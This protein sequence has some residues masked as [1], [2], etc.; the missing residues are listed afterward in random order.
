M[1]GRPVIQPVARVTGSPGGV[2]VAT[3]FDFDEQVP[4]AI[5]TP[6]AVE[7][8]GAIRSSALPEDVPAALRAE[9]MGSASSRRVDRVACSVYCNDGMIGNALIAL[10]SF[11]RVAPQMRAVM[12]TAR[13]QDYLW[14][15]GIDV[16]DADEP[17]RAA[18]IDIDAWSRQYPGIVGHYYRKVAMWLYML[19]QAAGAADWHIFIDADVLFLRG[20]ESMLR[21]ARA[22]VFAA[23]IEHWHPSIW[24]VFE[25]EGPGLQRQVELLFHGQAGPERMRR[26]TYFNSGFMLAREDEDVHAAVKDVLAASVLYPGLSRS[27]PFSEQTLF[28]I[29]TMARRVVCRDLYGMCVPSYHDESRG[30]PLPVARHYLADKPHRDPP[31]LHR[32]YPALVEA[33]LAAIGTSVDELKDRQLFGQTVAAEG[34][35]PLIEEALLAE[36]AIAE[37]ALLGRG[38]STATRAARRRRAARPDA[39]SRAT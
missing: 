1:A 6:N 10:G 9:A 27:I 17:F 16:V 3:S 34:S 24:S 2:E 30:W 19:E 4:A 29:A 31:V 28:N 33:S 12:F 39:F 7:T 32:R 37:E 18:H 14:V 23:M 11:K 26:R 13:P 36:D 15:K 21:H 38:G 22:H 35:Q 25:R 5:E 8:P 20:I